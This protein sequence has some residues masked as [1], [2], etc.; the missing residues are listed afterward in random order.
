MRLGIVS[1]RQQ[2]LRKPYVK[3]ERKS[4]LSRLHVFRPLQTQP[5]E[6]MTPERVCTFMEDLLGALAYMHSKGIV[7]R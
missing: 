1:T 3:L 5:I 4:P 6:R 2:R 7:R